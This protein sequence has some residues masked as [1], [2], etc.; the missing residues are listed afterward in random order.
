M[1]GGLNKSE[2]QKFVGQHSPNLLTVLQMCNDLFRSGSPEGKKEALKFIIHFVGDAHQPMH[3]SHKEDK[4]GNTI[5]V[6]F[7]GKGTNLHSFWD[8]KLIDHEHLSDA[9]LIAV[10]DKATDAE[11]QQWQSDEIIDWL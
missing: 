8:S 1:P 7:D 6:Q 2:F 9:Q 5:Q 3:V 11:V 10:C 4:G